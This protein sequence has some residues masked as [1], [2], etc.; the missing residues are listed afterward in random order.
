MI[1]WS[2]AGG[3]NVNV[4]K[5]DEVFAEHGCRFRPSVAQGSCTWFERESLAKAL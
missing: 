1:S 4:G 5:A 3:R 2:G